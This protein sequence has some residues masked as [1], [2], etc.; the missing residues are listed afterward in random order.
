MRAIVIPWLRSGWHWIQRRR[1]MAAWSAFQEVINST[2]SVNSAVQYQ[3]ENVKTHCPLGCVHPLEVEAGHAVAIQ[4]YREERDV[5][6]FGED[7]PSC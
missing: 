2:F 5:K 6:V 1:R 4:I 3:D 7:V